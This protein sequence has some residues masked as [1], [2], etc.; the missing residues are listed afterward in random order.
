MR[1]AERA[2]PRAPSPARE[3]STHAH[4][5]DHRR[6]SRTRRAT[7]RRFGREGFA[8]ALLSRDQAKL[9]ELAATL[10][11]EGVDARGYAADVL[12]GAALEGALQRAAADLGAITA[13]QYSPLPSRDYL[14]PVLDL[15]PELASEALRFSAIGLIH[16]DDEDGDKSYM[17]SMSILD[18]DL[19]DI[20]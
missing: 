16:A 13:L 5:R 3:G 4:H 17:F 8:V 12:D 18:I 9:D 1:C 14:K 2:T 10:Q 19:E 7:A 20:E 15:T 6:R 11:G